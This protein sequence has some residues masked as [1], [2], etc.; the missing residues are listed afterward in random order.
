M[1][2][3]DLSGRLSCHSQGTLHRIPIERAA[4][5]RIEPCGRVSLDQYG[6]SYRSCGPQRI[7]HWP[8]FPV[9]AGVR[10]M[11]VWWKA[12]VKAGDKYAG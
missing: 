9:N 3:P 6:F 8:H 11:P 1:P 7:R 4:S 2:T 10:L 12:T 5:R